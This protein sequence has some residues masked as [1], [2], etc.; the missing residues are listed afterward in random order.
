MKQ[1]LDR[2][3]DR[4]F[5]FEDL[6][7][8]YLFVD[9]CHQFRS[10]PYVTSYNQV[11]G[12]GPAEGSN[13]AV[14]LLT[15]MRY[16]Q[17]MHQGDKGTIFLSGTTIN[18]SLVEIYNLLNYLRPRKL[19][20]LGM[21]TFDAWAST[22][23]VHSAEIEAGT[24]G[25]FKS[26]DRF[27]SFDN[28]PELSQLYAEIADVRNDMNLQLPKPA[29]DART[30]IVKESDALHEIYQAIIDM[31]NTKNG[32]YFGIYPKGEPRKHPWG[33]DAST[34]SAKAAISPKLIFPDIEDD[35]G[36]IASVCENVGKIFKETAEHKGVQ[37][38][39]CELGVPGPGKKYDAYTDMINRLSKEYGIPRKAIAYIQQAK[40]DKEKEELFQRV[41]NGEVR[42]LIGGT[43]NMGTGVNVQD[44]ITDLHMLSVPWQP[45]SL[46]QCI[47][48]GARQG[49]II[50]RD[51]MGN[52]VRVL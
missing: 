22:F 7:V 19:E 39:F 41:R 37:L 45:A 33:L 43:K 8:D 30:V 38:I 46:E 4:E 27:R 2:S 49:N 29:I 3:V 21:T 40:N 23:A 10:L 12:L 36:K 25:E 18:N 48:R 34:L 6:G 5:C 26:K 35:G 24:T 28:V 14:A 16:L 32:S 9:E 13:K 20:A 50:A 17:K 51:F 1:R 31:L 42:I 15:G 44:R 11:A 47:G 52:K